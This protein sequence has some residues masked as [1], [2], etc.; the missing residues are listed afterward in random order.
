ME[1]YVQ[2]TSWRCTCAKC[3][4]E[5]YMQLMCWKKCVS[6]SYIAMKSILFLRV[7][8]VSWILVDEMNK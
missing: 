8:G 4:M 3:I 2:N 5:M 7:E 6:G 1:M